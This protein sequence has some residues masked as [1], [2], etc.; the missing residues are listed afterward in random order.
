MNCTEARTLIHGQSDGELEE[1][2][3]LRIEMHMDECTGCARAHKNTVSLKAALA[4]DAMYYRAPSDLRRRV[5]GTLETAEKESPVADR[6][7]RKLWLAWAPGFAFVAVIAAS[8]YVFWQSPAGADPLTQELVAAHVRSLMADHITDVLSTDQ[9]TV[10]PWFEGKLDFAPSV[11]DLGPEGFELIGG[12]LDYAAD[13]PVAALVYKRRQ[14]VINL[15]IF[16]RPAA[17]DG[18]LGTAGKQGYNVI[19]WQHSGMTFWAVS[20]LNAAEL[21][22][23]CQLYQR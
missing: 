6:G 17:S 3:N 15:F 10:K 8:L 16:P 4:D 9:H 22:Q 18:Q 20:D 5:I 12:R 7:L 23:F 1:V 13:R 19:G 11:I 21:Q 2:D 14:H